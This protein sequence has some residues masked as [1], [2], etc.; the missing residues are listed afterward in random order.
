MTISSSPVDQPLRGIFYIILSMFFFSIMSLMIKYLT[1]DYDVMQVTFFRCLFALLPVIPLA[2]WQVGWR[3]IKTARIRGHLWR[4]GTGFLAMVFF[5]YS[6]SLMHL[7]DAVAFNFAGPIF[8]ALFAIFLL[9]EKVGIHRW[10]GILLGFIGVLVMLQPGGHSTISWQAAA[11]AL[12][13]AVFYGLAMTGVRTLAQ[14]EKSFT[15]VFYF[16]LITTI[17]SGLALPFVWQMP[18]PSDWLWFIGSGFFAMLGQIFLTHAYRFAPAAVVTPFNYTAIIWATLFGYMMW[19]ETP[20]THVLIG[21]MIVIAA[22]CYIVYREAY[23]KNALPDA[24]T[25]ADL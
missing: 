18:Q 7:A 6:F 22:G 5:F 19:Q 15:I 16:A 4:S 17:L 24:V 14:T 1:A 8:A 20:T 11:V 25:K 23:R 2:L 13:S 9:R 12:A 21:A 3:G 10:I